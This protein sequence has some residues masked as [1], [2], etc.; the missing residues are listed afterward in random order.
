MASIQCDV[1][2]GQIINRKL[3]NF[4]PPEYEK[5]KSTLIQDI[6]IVAR[7]FCE[8]ELTMLHAINSGTARF[9]T[10]NNY[11]GSFCIYIEYV[12]TQVIKPVHV[13]H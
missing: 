6:A 9:G 12:G 10:I 1:A 4:K 5:I 7:S 11:L 3:V 13:C 2:S 8:S